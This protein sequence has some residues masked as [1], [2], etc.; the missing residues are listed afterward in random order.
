[1]VAI[2]GWYNDSDGSWYYYDGNGKAGSDFTKINGAWYYL[3]YNGYMTTSTW[4][5][6]NGYWYYITPSGVMA[7]SCYVVD[8]CYYYFEAS[9]EMVTGWKILAASGT[10]CSQV[11]RWLLAGK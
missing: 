5:Q 2:T 4:V 6:S 11:E 10:I 7:T 9:G 8:G 3:K 1:M